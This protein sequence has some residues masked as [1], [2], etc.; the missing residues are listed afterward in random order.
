LGLTAVLAATPL[1]AVYYQPMMHDPDI[2]WRLRVGEFITTTHGFPH[3]AIF[4]RFAATNTWETHSWIFDVLVWLT[5]KWFSLSGLTVF[6]FVFQIAIA[7]VMI[8]SLVIISQSWWK[9][10]L[11]SAVCLTASFHT[12]APRAALFT[13]LLFLLEMAV[14]FKDLRERRVRAMYWLP[15]IFLVWANCHIQFVNG[16]VVLG[17]LCGCE[18]LQHFVAANVP[19]SSPDL[20]WS[21]VLLIFVGCVVATL[22]NPYS[23]HLYEVIWGYLTKTGQWDQIV[24]LLAPDFRRPAHYVELLLAGWAA[25][26]LGARRTHS[27]FRISLLAV[28]AIISFHAIREAWMIAIVASFLIADCEDGK[29]YFEKLSIPALATGAVLALAICMAAQARVGFTNA[30][31]I[32]E[33]DRTFPVRAVSFVADTH[34]RGPIYNSM[35][36]G[37]Y[38]IFNLR[39]YPVAMDGRN[40]AYGGDIGEYNKVTEGVPGWKQNPTFAT[41]N[42]VLIEKNFPLARLLAADPDFKLIYEDHLAMVFVRKPR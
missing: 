8:G 10:L 24:E 14:I 39:E 32:G 13:V 34:P 19:N 12:L 37:G 7:A 38:L 2:W 41:S 36:W 42:L 40:E 22:V 9:G 23:W 29:K 1:A 25:W 31:L 30:R 11:L 6:L 28:S 17:L 16:F 18:F 33:L 3:M 35:N 20:P 15:L 21:K 27:L 5:Y 4:S 26:S